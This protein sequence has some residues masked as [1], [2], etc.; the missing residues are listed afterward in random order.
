MDTSF[1]KTWTWNQLKQALTERKI[2][3]YPQDSRDYLVALLQDS[4]QKA[5][6]IVYDMLTQY[7]LENLIQLRR[8]QY[9]PQKQ[10]REYLTD[11]LIY[12]DMMNGISYRE[13]PID[14]FYE[15][16]NDE[17]LLNVVKARNI[18]VYP[19]YTR[20]ML[21]NKL[22]YYDEENWI[23]HARP[24]D[25]Y[26][27][28]YYQAPGP[29]PQ[30]YQFVQNKVVPQ[31]SRRSHD[32]R[33]V[34]LFEGIKYI[35]SKITYEKYVPS[36]SENV[37]LNEEKEEI[38]TPDMV[39]FRDGYHKLGIN[40]YNG[41]RFEQIPLME[42]LM[43]KVDEIFIYELLNSESYDR[44][45]DTPDTIFNL[46]WYLTSYYEPS[47]RV[48][49]RD[50]QISYISSLFPNDLLELVGPKYN[51]PKDR[52]SLIFAANTGFMS[53]PPDLDTIPGYNVVKTWDPSAVWNL[54]YKFGI[55]EDDFV[56]PYPPYV[57][58]AMHYDEIQGTHPP[59]FK[60]KYSYEEIKEIIKQ[61]E[62]KYNLRNSL[63][64]PFEVDIDNYIAN[65]SKGL[66][67]QP[68]ELWGGEK[69][70]QRIYN[71]LGEI[72]PTMKF[73]MTQVD[74]KFIHALINASSLYRKF[75]GEIDDVYNFLW[76]LIYASTSVKLS[77]KQSFYVSSL[78]EKQLLILLGPKYKGPK[79][80][81]SLVFA[82]L[83]G[84][85]SH[86]P[87]LYSLPAYNTVKK[88]PPSKVWN[89]AEIYGI[90]D[91]KPSPYSPHVFVAM[92]YKDIQKDA[93]LPIEHI[94]IRRKLA[95]QLYEPYKVKD[96][97]R[98]EDTL[99]EHDPSLE[100][101]A[102]IITNHTT[103]F[104]VNRKTYNVFDYFTENPDKISKLIQILGFGNLH[105]TID[106]YYN[107]L[108]YLNVAEEPY[109][110][111]LNPAEKS[112]LSTLDMRTILNL[113]G[114]NYK[115]PQDKASLIFAALS[116][117]STYPRNVDLS[118]NIVKNWQP[119]EIWDLAALYGIMYKG[120]PDKYSPYTYVALKYEQIQKDLKLPK[121]HVLLRR[122]LADESFLPYDINPSY[123]TYTD[124][125][126]LN[127]L[128]KL[129]KK[130]TYFKPQG[131]QKRTIFEF[132]MQLPERDIHKLMQH[133]QFNQLDDTID[134]YYNLLWYINLNQGNIPVNVSQAV[135]SYISGAENDI[136]LDLL[137]ENYTGPTD[138][139]SLIFAA[140]SG[141]SSSSYND[142]VSSPEY[143]II[144]QWDP[145]TVW[146]HARAYG[147]FSPK[148]QRYPPHLY[149]VMNYVNIMKD[150][151]AGYSLEEVSI[152]GKIPDEY[153]SYT[154]AERNVSNYI[155]NDNISPEEIAAIIGQK[156]IISISGKNMLILDFL[157][158][159]KDVNYAKAVVQE[160]GF[161]KLEDD[162][163]VYYDLLWYI[164]N[165]AAPFNLDLDADD[166]S[167]ISGL[168]VEKLRELLGN[169]YKGAE[170]RASM[171]FSMI[172]GHLSNSPMS[173]M[174]YEKVKFWDPAKVSELTDIYNYSKETDEYYDAPYINVASHYDEIKDI[175][176]YPLEHIIIWKKLKDVSFAPFDLKY[177]HQTLNT[178]KNDILNYK[179]LAENLGIYK[180][181]QIENKKI[182]LFEIIM[183]WEEISVNRLIE[184]LGFN[185]ML[186]QS[187]SLKYSIDVYYDLL[188]YINTAYQPYASNLNLNEKAYISGLE[189]PEL[190]NLLGPKYNGPRNLSSAIFAVISGRSAYDLGIENR[191]LY[192]PLNTWV[193]ITDWLAY[194][195]TEFVSPYTYLSLT[196]ENPLMDIAGV[197]DETNI[198]DIMQKYGIVTPFI[199]TERDDIIFTI[200]EL[201]NYDKILT[202]PF[203]L[204]VPPT[205][206]VLQKIPH[207]EIK[208]ILSNYTLRELINAY[209]PIEKWSDRE[210]LYTIIIKESKE[211]QPKW[212]WR[213]N[214]CGNDDANHVIT[215]EP[216]GEVN[217]D[218]PNDPTLSYGT[219]RLYR[220][221]QASELVTMFETD[222]EDGIFYFRVPDWT[223][224][225]IDLSTGEPLARDFT[226]S[227]I[228]ELRKLLERNPYQVRHLIEKIDK[229]LSAQENIV[230][231]LRK[232]QISYYDKSLEEQYL[233]QLY[234][235]WMFI[236]GMWIRFWKG[237]GNPWP[238][239]WIE[240][241]N[242]HD[243]CS[244]GR[245]DEHIFI[246]QGVHTAL[247]NEY[248]KYPGLKTWIESLPLINY[249]F[250]TG[251]IRVALP[252]DK[253]GIATILGV[254][255]N[256]QLGDF[257]MAH[258]TDLILKTSYYLIWI[259]LGFENIDQFNELID[260]FLPKLL[261]IEK[262]VIEYQLRYITNPEHKK[263]KERVAA[264]NARLT[265]LKQ[266]TPIQPPFDPTRLG[267]TGHQDPYH[268]WRMRF[269]K[270]K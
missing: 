187:G 157:M 240:D 117:R 163:A 18:R 205:L 119:D 193:I 225:A 101:I 77:D 206:P 248:E 212:S 146:K 132:L 89:Y 53:H 57:F 149:L 63:F 186:T 34:K 52:A 2:R 203:S 148:P 16:L 183:T 262:D 171:L 47:Y 21:I 97:D 245:R 219:Q 126:Q 147:V 214:W 10:S 162:I 68:E 164:I 83:T 195:E 38:I 23:I 13:I 92:H 174:N 25:Y 86:S 20:D 60:P 105:D 45:Y 190:L 87:S 151:A 269:E 176:E 260:A 26:N 32:P 234:L 191:L 46:L 139:A 15:H 159:Y 227:S 112:Y 156:D 209:E 237:P 165:A 155:A 228:I 66:N 167:Y 134:V 263:V 230:N 138:R 223:E 189:L 207:G 202:R 217:K 201:K 135:L 267:G 3:V 33:E 90:L 143:E 168:N 264:L 99:F 211:S 78:K 204:E 235:V 51:G 56:S 49:L 215:L 154:W 210:T 114:P 123:E 75:R 224:G 129:I 31:K 254:L 255:D 251:D 182:E 185:Q 43:T 128:S 150:K 243:R 76:Y 188:W 261:A 48:Y 232:I 59:M 226:I 268:G 22:N 94:S 121:I 71:N 244:I 30:P 145:Y 252:N 141:R 229:G 199:G 180:Y 236:Y 36:L 144:K 28:L 175:I 253:G 166:I 62:I 118:Y 216:K 266:P 124:V 103:Y 198:D 115:G 127:D 256:I 41:E 44:L 107:L 50:Y 14:E 111:G 12:H 29:K 64:E 27:A 136:L 265:E 6:I 170:D 140:M 173:I 4:D 85:S 241:G 61:N 7:E 67:I 42:F 152:I 70:Y 238:I 137:G 96:I 249:D 131:K 120:I 100:E 179:K 11:V 108:W 231:I 177:V 84:Q 172:S 125:I 178:P 54:A 218:D 72:L 250:I 258:G 184:S 9:N 257:C 200:K 220:C 259:I 113:L 35:L 65:D 93:N 95:K 247:K 169:Q 270:K 192:N 109:K 239:E 158:K 37:I 221:Y 74:T 1:Y 161:D 130:Y 40:Y 5:G 196:R 39:I 246:Q 73:L 69:L 98:N 81:A 222:P 181:V 104:R 208:A 91:D 160:L 122:K 17:Q 79:D 8:L 80:H 194:T 106:V 102:N 55:I 19:P 116:G 133:L 213:H 233:I 142:I 110:V 88:W 242:R 82:V 24:E 153:K 58:V 197:I